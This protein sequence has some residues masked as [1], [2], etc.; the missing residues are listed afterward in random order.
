M[1]QNQK[2]DKFNLV[3]ILKLLKLEATTVHGRCNLA[4]VIIVTGFCLLYTAG[5]TIS[6]TISSISDT[7]KTIALKE[8]IHHP[9]ESTSLIHVLIPILAII[10]L[11]LLYLYIHEK[12]KVIPKK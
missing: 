12:R 1:K 11:C 10:I 5:D 7:V 4:F 3:N 9:Y 8:D 6:Y 2:S